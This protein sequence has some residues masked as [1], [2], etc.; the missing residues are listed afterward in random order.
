MVVS[1]SATDAA[2]RRNTRQPITEKS[3]PP[4]RLATAI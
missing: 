1:R 3:D 2:I 4:V